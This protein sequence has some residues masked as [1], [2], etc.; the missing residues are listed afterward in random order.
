D[1]TAFAP[2]Q[3]YCR[4]TARRERIAPSTGTSRKPRDKMWGLSFLRSTL[5]WGIGNSFT[6]ESLPTRAARDTAHASLSLPSTLLRV[7]TPSDWCLPSMQPT[8]PR[9]ASTVGSALSRGLSASCTP[10]YARERNN[11]CDQDFCCECRILR[12]FPTDSRSRAIHRREFEPQHV[13][14]PRSSSEFNFFRLERTIGRA[15]FP[16]LFTSGEK[17]ATPNEV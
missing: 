6:W 7:I 10:V 12:H 8:N 13:I 14:H 2:S 3:R 17:D 5:G 1:S 9:C 15:R 11:C 4:A 16:T